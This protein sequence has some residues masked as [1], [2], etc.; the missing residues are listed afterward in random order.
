MNKILSKTYFSEKVVKLE[1]E[2]PLIA[3]ARKPGN[4]VIVRVGEKGERM[5]LT[6]ADANLERG[7]I[8][9]VVQ[10]MGVS[11]RKLCALEVGDYITD[12]VGPLGKPTHIEKVGTVLACGG[13]VGVAPLLPIVRAFKEAG[14]RVVSVIAGRNK[15][16]VI[17]E[18]EIRA[19]SDEVIIMTDD[20]SYGKKG[21]ITEGMEEV[22]K[23]EKV[24]LAV[25]IG[26][27][28]MMKF[29]ERLT[30]KYDIPTVASLN[31]LMVDGTGMCGACRVTVGGKTRFTCVDGPEFDAHL[32]DFD[33]ILS[34]LGGFKDAEV[35][36]LHD[37]EVKQEESEHTHGVSDRN[38][39][40][41]QEL[42]QK[43]AGKERTSIERVHMPETAP[44]ER[45]KSQRIEVNQG[46]TADMAMREAT[47][48]MDC[49]T[50]TCMEGCPVGIDIPGF[51]KNIER[52][53]FLQAAAVLK[54]TS[55]LPAVCGRV[56]PQEKQCESKC[57]YLQKL[58]KPS[59][60]IGYLERFASDFERE[61]G[62]ITVPEVAHANGIKVAVI[63][64]GPSGLSCA[65]DLAKLGYDVTVFEALHEIGGVLKYGIPEFRLPNSVVDVEIDNLK[66]IGV[67]F[68]TNFIVGMTDSVEDLKAEGFKAFYVASGA[69]L[70][71]F[72]NIP[73]ENYNGILSSNEY[74]TRVNLM[75]ADSEDSDTPVYRGKNVVVVGGGNTA[76]DSVR[77]AK[78]LGAERAMIVYRRSEEEMPA[79]LEEVKHAKEEGCE[80]ITLTNP[81]EYIADERGR[82]KQVR[83]QKM[84]LGEPDASGRRSPV[85]V[86]GSEYT[87]D[88]DV[89][90]VAV[91]VSPN[92]IVPNSVKGLEISRKGT[93]VVNDETMQSNLSEFFAGGDIVRGGATV[94]LAMGDGRR[95]AKHID[96]MFKAN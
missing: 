75:G 50:P 95:A 1:V 70:P 92:P 93:I 58:K 30:R 67:K 82:V 90:V 83:V 41:R 51:V 60:A 53:E 13:G 24:D 48:C 40:W 11:S 87:I 56:C 27:A 28:I 8:T 72:M 17:L 65:G 5:P 69:G 9:L 46:L 20:G 91:G 19:S 32:I 47:R 57:F 88:A 86:E 85:P 77:T 64:S 49:V 25:T 26:P 23:R 94:I 78:R 43:V 71:R 68:V 66:K 21:L 36:K 29:C 62:H 96:E 79:R 59:V 4:F 38:E 14:N 18:D 81:V 44:E 45:I 12:L 10:V 16:L 76:M 52:G 33:E 80:F 54:R 63:G 35:A 37:V 31:A 89:V 6:I 73:G 74:L 55:A 15:D 34:R 3:K 84:A 22:I 61:S 2:A 42:R 7:S 39:P